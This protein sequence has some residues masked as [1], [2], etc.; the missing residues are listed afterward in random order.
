[1]FLAELD[2]RY[3]KSVD[4]DVLQ[5]A[6]RS[7]GY[8]F[9]CQ[10]CASLKG[11]AGA[12]P[13]DPSKRKAL[14]YAVCMPGKP[15]GNQTCHQ[16]LSKGNVA[17]SLAFGPERR[18]WFSELMASWADGQDNGTSLIYI[19]LIILLTCFLS[20]LA[21]LVTLLD[22]L[23]NAEQFEA[24]RQSAS[25]IIDHRTFLLDRLQFQLLSATAIEKLGEPG[26][27]ISEEETWAKVS[28]A[29]VEYNER[30]RKELEEREAEGSA[31]KTGLPVQEGFNLNISEATPASGT[32]EPLFLPAQEGDEE[33]GLVGTGASGDGKG[34]REKAETKEGDNE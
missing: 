15:G 18:N 29:I 22:L 32:S 25:L 3:L 19:S 7:L 14:T 10:H 21:I 12:P 28:T 6:T 2:L 4:L 31:P 27:L 34:E 17:C 24:I 8:S 1:M 23:R 13:K 9:P 26:T 30:R 16:C 11:A 33:E 20:F 5:A